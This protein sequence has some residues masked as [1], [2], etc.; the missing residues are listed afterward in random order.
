MT[1]PSPSVDT[2]RK[3]PVPIVVASS[4]SYAWGAILLVS[5]VAVLLPLLS[6]P[7][8]FIA[9]LGFLSIVLVI[10][11][12]YCLS[13]YLIHRRRS[14]GAWFSATLVTLTTALQLVMHLNF[15]GVNMKPPWLLVNALLLVLLVTNWARLR[16]D[17]TGDPSG[18]F[19]DGA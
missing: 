13:G 11:V 14:I 1:T 6:R 19:A 12:A 17:R 9:A 7:R 3:Q 18:R 5:T 8:A 15:W 10:A 16:G 2:P 4:L